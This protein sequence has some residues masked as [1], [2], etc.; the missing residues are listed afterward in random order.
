MN[1]RLLWIR[2]A[3]PMLAVAAL[4]VLAGCPGGQQEA[5]VEGRTPIDGTWRLVRVLD[6]PFPRTIKLVYTLDR[7]KG[8]FEKEGIPQGDGFTYTADEEKITLKGG[9]NEGLLDIHPESGHYPYLRYTI[10]RRRM[11]WWVWD[12]T[13]SSEKRTMYIF[14]RK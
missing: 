11:V 1:V 4:V 10:E 12:P 14:E 3:A 6:T 5:Q 2:H 7:G 13:S 8:T 9:S